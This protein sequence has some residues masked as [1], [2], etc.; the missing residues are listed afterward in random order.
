MASRLANPGSP[1]MIWFLLATYFLG[2]GLGGVSVTGLTPARVQTITESVVNVVPPGERADAAQDVL[3]Q[4]KK[5]VTRHGRKLA[6]TGIS[7][8]RA[9]RD[10]D[11]D[12]A[13]VL[14]RLEALNAEWS[15]DQEEVLELRFALRELLTESEWERVFGSPPT[16]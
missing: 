15:V 3:K 6:R 5:V 14:D 13:A 16:P 12:A 10:H 9:Y 11:A 4:L 2:G 8:N 1:E 7:L